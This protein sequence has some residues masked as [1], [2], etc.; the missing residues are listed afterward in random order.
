MKYQKMVPQRGPAGIAIVMGGLGLTALGIYAATKD[1]TERK[2]VDS[3]VVGMRGACWGGGGGAAATAHRADAELVVHVA[4]IG[5]F[6]PPVDFP[7]A[8]FFC[9]LPLPASATRVSPSSTSG[10]SERTRCRAR[11][12]FGELPQRLQL[13]YP[14]SF[15]LLPRFSCCCLVSCVCFIL[16]AALQLFVHCGVSLLICDTDLC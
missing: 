9:S 14:S 4:V 13:L 16:P 2:C 12:T 7:C 15:L 1:I 8:F 10:T 5:S 11:R 3:G 6:A